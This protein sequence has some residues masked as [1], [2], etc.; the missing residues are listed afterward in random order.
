MNLLTP[1]MGNTRGR[2]RRETLKG[3]ERNT[4]GGGEKHSRGRRETLKGAERNTVGVQQNPGG[5]GVQ[6]HLS[7]GIHTWE[8][9]KQHSSVRRNTRGVRQHRS[10][11]HI[12]CSRKASQH[13]LRACRHK[14][15]CDDVTWDFCPYDIVASSSA[16]VTAQL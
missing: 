2:Q 8:G 13:L 7:A 12:H 6:K 14:K 1:S 4:Q 16:V 9:V 15:N 10:N 11:P 5:K 3:A